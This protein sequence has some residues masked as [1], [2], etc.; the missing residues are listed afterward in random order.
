M[1]LDALSL[2]PGTALEADLCIVGGGA[3]GLTLAS[4]LEDSGLSVLLLEAGGRKFDPKSQDG[5]QGSVAP[6]S[7]HS[8][9]HMYRRRVLGG[10]TAIWGGRCVPFDPIDLER[11]DW[12]EGSGWPLPWEEL[13]SYYPAAQE[14]CEAGAYAYDVGTALP[15]GAPPTIEGFSDP[16]LV[17]D[18]LERFSR[19]TDFG[20]STFARLAAAARVR[21]LL[22]A[23]AVR[24]A[25]DGGPVERLEGASAPGRGFTVR[26]RRYV[27]AT[28]G[29][30]VPR[31]LMASD[32]SRRGGLGNEG[33]ALGRFYMCHA[34]NTLGRLRLNPAGRPVALDFE[35]TE[36]GTY[37]RRKFG[38]SAA[39]QRRE[40][41]LNTIFRLHYPLIA[42]PAHGSGVLSAMYLVKDAILPEYRRKLA[43]IEIANRGRMKRDAAFWARHMA[44]VVLDSPGVLK[45]GQAWL[46]KRTFAS[47]KLP[48]VVVR[49]RDGS[50][51]L[52]VN[53]EQ[54]PNPDS[55]V[56]LT[57]ERDAFGLPRLQV[58]WR[59][60]PQD[61]DSLVRS[62]RVARDAFA[63][64][65]TATLEFDDATIEDEVRASTPVGG[66]HIGT[67]RMAASAH[68]GVVDADCAVHGVPNLYVASAAVFP[69]SSHA[70]PTLTIVALALRLA[71]HLKACAARDAA[72]AAQAVPELT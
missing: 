71:D 11:R 35:V 45:F 55:R 59:L 47:R 8:P 26:A 9:P 69:T 70:N 28:G 34:E 54:V 24:L 5:L 14:H 22:N 46:R 31:L 15:P 53:A 40:G 51:P 1:I 4:A 52:D 12:V 2:P 18:R 58:D 33:G 21:I 49:S 43:T 19:P 44:N 16:D 42:D 29:L 37:V 10:A 57:A 3:A 66:H 67:A 39:A 25:A 20:K 7:S 38:L 61:I 56:T 17:S 36:D 41:L 13:A 32:D 68:E 23:H 72:P 50:Y 62:M 63:R 48:F 65:G 64:S 27:L 60:H 6:G 30:E